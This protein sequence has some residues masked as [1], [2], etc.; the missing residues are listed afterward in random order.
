MR[1]RI[2]YGANKLTINDY[3]YCKTIRSGKFT[4][5]PIVEFKCGDKI[6]MTNKELSDYIDAEFPLITNVHFTDPTMWSR[7]LWSFMKYHNK[8]SQKKRTWFITT[9]GHKYD[10]KFL[11]QC[12]HIM[13]EV[14]VPSSMME[15]P[16]EFISWCAED[17]YITDKIEYKFVVPA[18]AKDI[19]FTRSELVKIGTYDK[20][21]TIERGAGWKSFREF[22]DQFLNTVRYP[23]LHIQP[24]I[25][26]L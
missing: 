16:P 25:D 24:N 8:N 19:T 3:P 17:R 13:I 11:Y 2:D 21:I 22:E 4:G 12:D 9:A 1:K 14:K 15:T 5:T 23:Y 7:E 26:E 10:V 18:N 20:P 6:E